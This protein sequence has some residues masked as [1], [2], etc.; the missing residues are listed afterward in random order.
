MRGVAGAWTAEARYG[1]MGGKKGIFWMKLLFDT[2][3]GSDID[4]ALALAYL[5]KEPECEL[6][7]V[8]TVTGEPELR[9]EMVSSICRNVGRGDIPVHV[10]CPLPMAIAQRQPKA[11][12]AAKLGAWDR[13]HY[14]TKNTAIE[15]LR[16]TIRSNPGEVV[17]LA[18][19]P[20]T[21]LG[22][23]FTLDPELPSLLK[24][25][26]LMCGRF[27]EGMG[28]EWNAILD[29]WATGIVYGNTTHSRPPVHVSYGLDV[30]LKVTLQ[31]DE[32]RARFAGIDALAP[33]R[34][35]AEVWFER[36]ERVVFHDP[37]AAVGVFHPEVCEYNDCFVEVSQQNPTLGW[38]IPTWNEG[39]ARVHRVAQ[40]VNAEAFFDRYFG[41]L[42]A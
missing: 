9:A 5:L 36:C 23:L 20:L 37:L 19:G 7:G 32:A 12:Q 39:R 1:K 13:A 21:N 11:P 26:V 24:G 2:D 34:D 6:L 22:V 25:L 33:V 15:F 30:T 18:T 8:T 14:A 3:I 35:F 27:F 16:E 29:P 17:L 42:K 40:R 4:D 10:G 28:G 38:T 31:R 41:T